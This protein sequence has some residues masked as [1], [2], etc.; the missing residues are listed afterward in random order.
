MDS[1]QRHSY[2]SNNVK[3]L[4]CVESCG[5]PERDEYDDLFLEN[6]VLNWNAVKKIFNL[7]ESMYNT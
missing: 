3:E 5:L 1:N 4:V 7:N 6:G 2:L